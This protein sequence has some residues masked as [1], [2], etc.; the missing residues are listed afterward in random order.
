MTWWQT[1]LVGAVPVTITALALLTQQALTARSAR[2]LHRMQTRTSRRDEVLA[3][4]R[5]ALTQLGAIEDTVREPAFRTL[6]AID[7]GKSCPA[8]IEV[9][10]E[11]FRAADD[12][13]AAV[14][15]LCSEQSGKT[16]LEYDRA[17]NALGA[18][19]SI[20]GRTADELHAALDAASSARTAYTL[21]ARVELGVKA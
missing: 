1:L 6:D 3:V 11:L 20:P 2:E 16:C 8:G 13:V 14:L 4:H 10:R 19:V 5:T 21:T 18:T 12:A 15:L 9:P 17:V 7:K